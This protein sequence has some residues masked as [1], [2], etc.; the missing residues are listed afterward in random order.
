IFFN[1]GLTSFNSF[2]LSEFFQN[3]LRVVVVVI[4]LAAR[5][6]TILS[7]DQNF[8][9]KFIENKQ[10]LSIIIDML[11]INN[12][13]H[14]ICLILQTLGIIA[15]NPNFHEVLTQADIPDTV[16][17]LILPADEMFYT[18]QTTKFARYVK[19]LGARILVYMGL[20]TKL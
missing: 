5:L 20:L 17:H 8:Q 6:L 11:N 18:N 4:I 9:L 7:Q 15:L 1:N 3:H 16:L 19:H 2:T 14:L 13:P 12:D 10:N